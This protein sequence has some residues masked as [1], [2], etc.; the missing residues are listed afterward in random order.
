MNW[1]D[2][3]IKLFNWEYWPFPIVYAPIFL[4]WVWLSFRARSLLYFTAA[5]PCMKNGGMLGESKIDILKQLPAEN[6]PVTI[7]MESGLD[8]SSILKKITEHGLTFPL[9]VKPDTGERG[10][11]VS[12]LDSPQ[13]LFTYARSCRINFLVQEFIDLPV[14]VGIFYIRYPGKDHG[15]ITSL[16]RKELLRITG[17]G[18]ST[19]RTLVESYDRAYLQREKLSRTWQKQWNSIPAKDEEWVLEDIGNHCRGTKFLDGNMLIRK[20]LTV[21]FDNLAAQG[22]GFHVGRFDI[23]TRSVE[24]L[25]AGRFKIMELNGAGSEP[26]HIYDPALSL[27]EAYRSLFQHWKMLFEISVINHKEGIPYLSFREGI[28]EYQRVLFHQRMIPKV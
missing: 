16:T 28:K 11:G 21:L 10:N 19:L 2:F 6:V 15:A 24:D 14:E 9:I 5:N 7:F 4:Y 25:Y 20:E 27:R 23:R 1:R 26:S 12:R 17:D 3:R 22:P 13:E 8:D 18:T